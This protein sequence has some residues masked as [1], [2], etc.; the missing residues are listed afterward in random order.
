[1]RLDISLMGASAAKKT[2]QR[3]VVSG[4]LI[5]GSAAGCTVSEETE[6][7][8]Q[9]ADESDS[10]DAPKGSKDAGKGGKDAGS[11]SNDDDSDDLPEP[12]KGGKDASTTPAKD[13]GSTPTA[14]AGKDA[15]TTTPVK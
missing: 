7:D 3:L 9:T 2:W 1:M 15:G 8:G 4:L 12:P 10:D 11:S 6:D 14:D 5:A 13:G